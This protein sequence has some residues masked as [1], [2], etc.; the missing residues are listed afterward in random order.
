[1]SK[2]DGWQLQK[3]KKGR[4][5]AISDFT[6][7]EILARLW[8][9]HSDAGKKGKIM[10]GQLLQFLYVICYLH[11]CTCMP[12]C[13]YWQVVAF[14]TPEMNRELSVCSKCWVS[15]KAVCSVSQSE[16]ERD[17]GSSSSGCLPCT[18]TIMLL[19]FTPS[20]PH[21]VLWIQSRHNCSSNHENQVWRRN[22]SKRLYIM[23]SEILV[24]LC[25]SN[26]V[27][28]SGTLLT[29]TGVRGELGHLKIS[30]I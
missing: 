1:M 11:A 6:Y 22:F 9:I 19:P 17:R 10:I 4:K 15:L 13:T 21:F 5:K 28:F 7:H 20:S 18:P 8:Q 24:F 29:Y 2:I 14:Y 26:A 3:K 23:F 16:W 27:G 30:L 25:T 12:S